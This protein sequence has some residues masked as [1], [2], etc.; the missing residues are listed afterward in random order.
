[1]LNSVIIIFHF[2]S[3]SISFLFTGI[4]I[5][6]LELYVNNEYLGALLGKVDSSSM[7]TRKLCVTE[8]KGV[9]EHTGML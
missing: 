8:G 2:C 7:V 4:L 6:N 3:F 5:L 1:M 9:G